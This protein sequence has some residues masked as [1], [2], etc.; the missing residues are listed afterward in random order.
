MSKLTLTKKIIDLIHPIDCLGCGQEGDWLC[1]TCLKR[2]QKIRLEN[3]FICSKVASTGICQKCQIETGLDGIISVLP[4]R[5][6]ESQQLIYSSKYYGY[7]DALKFISEKLAGK[8]A[9]LLPDNFD[10]ITFVPMTSKKARE[11]GF[12]PA[13]LIAKEFDK[14]GLDSVTIFEKVRETESQT[15]LTKAK[16]KKNVRKV[17]S[18]TTRQLP[19]YLVIADDVITTG[20]TLGALA[21]LAKRR[22]TREIWAITICHG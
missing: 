7:H 17:F 22:G 1:P 11:R 2:F 4:Y 18:L 13:E 21:K 14:Y 12:N 19:E 16:R 10:Q 15:K 5:L 20:S 6:P 9:R 8:I 3:C